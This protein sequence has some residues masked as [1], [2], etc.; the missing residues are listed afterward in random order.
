MLTNDLGFELLTLVLG[1][2]LLTEGAP[3]S[4]ACPEK[5][6]YGQ[7][8]KISGC[9]REISDKFSQ[10]DCLEGGCLI[11]QKEEEDEG[12]DELV[13]IQVIQLQSVQ[14][15]EVQ[16]PAKSM[17][18]FKSQSGQKEQPQNHPK[19]NEDNVISS[20]VMTT[21]L[22]KQ[23]GGQVTR[24]TNVASLASP[25]AFGVAVLPPPRKNGR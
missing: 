14:R 15:E 23:D 2:V 24:L 19:P 13:C 8:L 5:W 18:D 9:V 1:T 25:F 10:Y 4:F 17:Q 7:L 22:D 12:V 6:E 16:L 20:T 3:V 21:L 11:G